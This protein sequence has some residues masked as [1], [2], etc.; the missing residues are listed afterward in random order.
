MSVACDVMMNAEVRRMLP[1]MMHERL[2]RN[3][4]PTVMMNGAVGGNWGT[5]LQ[6][7]HIG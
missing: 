3:C 1:V 6:S 4:R 2:E 5:R 7:E